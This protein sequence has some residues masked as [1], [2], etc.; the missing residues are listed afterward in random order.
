MTDISKQTKKQ[1]LETLEVYEEEKFDNFKIEFGL[2]YQTEED[3]ILFIKS[4]IT[5]NKLLEKDNQA[6]AA[7]NAHH[8]ARMKDTN[9]FS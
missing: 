1:L 2:P 8:T 5:K 6:W 9:T 3:W 7:I 4:L